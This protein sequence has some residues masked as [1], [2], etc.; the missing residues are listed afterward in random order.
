MNSNENSGVF[1]CTKKL[2]NS[3]SL[4]RV[5]GVRVRALFTA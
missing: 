1:Q 5:H 3:F 2:V 4:G